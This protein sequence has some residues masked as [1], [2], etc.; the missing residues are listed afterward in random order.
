MGLK[1]DCVI[2]EWS[3]AHFLPFLTVSHHYRWC[4][5]AFNTLGDICCFYC[6]LFCRPA[7]NAVWTGCVWG[8]M[9]CACERAACRG[10]RETWITPDEQYGGIW[11]VFYSPSMFFLHLKTGHHSLALFG[12]FCNTVFLWN[13]SSVLWTEKNKPNLQSAWG[14]VDNDWIFILGW[15]QTQVKYTSTHQQL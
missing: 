14:W 6:D 5:Q 15:T 13:S 4:F 10:F 3:S 2:T 9:V 7:T 8:V 1:S 11:C 12:R